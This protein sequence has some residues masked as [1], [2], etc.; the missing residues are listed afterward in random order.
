VRAPDNDPSLR[1]C[2]TDRL[3]GDTADVCGP[4]LRIALGAP[5][6][7]AGALKSLYDVTLYLLFR[8]LRE[9]APGQT[10][11]ASSAN[12]RSEVK[13]A[14]RLL[15]SSVSLAVFAERELVRRTPATPR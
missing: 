2:P 3:P 12:E 5:F 4:S 6:L 13:R 7:I 15:R 9:V 8:D 11:A 14:G 10:D 1:P